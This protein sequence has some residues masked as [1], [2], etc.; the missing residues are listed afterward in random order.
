M[1]T[2]RIFDTLLD[3][4]VALFQQ[5]TPSDQ[6]VLLDKLTETTS[7]HSDDSEQRNNLMRDVIYLPKPPNA[8][9][10]EELAGSWIDDRSAAEIVED[11]RRSRTPNRDKVNL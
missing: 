3:G 8:P 2:L 5:L 6:S 7:T 10:F 11:L 1:S 9:S 4:Y